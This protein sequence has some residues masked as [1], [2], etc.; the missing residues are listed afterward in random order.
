M[1]RRF[2]IYFSGELLAGRG[3]DEVRANLARLF[4]ANDQTLDRLFSGDLQLLKRDCD[5]ATASKYQTAMERA[6][7]VAIVRASDAAQ[8]PPPPAE[9]EPQAPAAEPSQDKPMTAAERIA[10]IA[11]TSADPRFGSDDDEERQVPTEMEWASPLDEQVDLRLTP[12]G[13]DVLLAQERAQPVETSIDTSQLSVDTT[14]QRLSEEPP[15]PPPAPDTSHLDM[16][17]VG[18]DIPNLPRSETPVN[19]DTSALDLSPEGSDFSDC[20]APAPAP[21]DLDL[22]AMDLAPEGS[23]VLEERFRRKDDTPAPATDHLSVED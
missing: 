1:D 9:P 19:P 2:N 4:N 20:A 17:A 3:V 15:P 14:A 8:A 22:S 11:G 16:G 5:E 7:A 18:D 13:T 10:A 6:G 21:P 23:D 12:E